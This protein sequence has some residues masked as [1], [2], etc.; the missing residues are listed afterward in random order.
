LKIL[1]RRIST[2][3]ENSNCTPAA[4]D[5]VQISKGGLAGVV[6]GSIIG[7][8]LIALATGYWFIQR[9]RIYPGH[10]LNT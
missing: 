6:L 4:S 7:T 3:Y 1:I 8:S 10:A 9:K 5:Y 2:D